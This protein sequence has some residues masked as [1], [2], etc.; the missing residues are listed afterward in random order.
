MSSACHAGTRPQMELG[1]PPGS[2]FSCLSAHGGA[3][4]VN[5]EHSFPAKPFS[6]PSEHV[7]K[8]RPKEAE[9]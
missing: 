8:L 6:H 3:L 1:C 5:L 4:G 7:G 9:V 2:S